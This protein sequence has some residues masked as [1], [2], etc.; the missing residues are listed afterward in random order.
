MSGAGT[1]TDPWNLTTPPGKSPFQI[2]RDEAKGVL[3]CQVGSTWLHY[4]P[5]AIEE[6]LMTAK[7][8]AA[9]GKPVLINA[10]IGKTD[11]RKGSLSM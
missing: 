10:L 9:A 6:V 3:H 11:F 8:E 5:E 1:P 4:K 2:W 7:R